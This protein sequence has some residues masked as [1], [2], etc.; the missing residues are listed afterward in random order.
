MTGCD[1]SIYVW[2]T[3]GLCVNYLSLFYPFEVGVFEAGNQS[4]FCSAA[5]LSYQSFLPML[6]K[7][8]T[9]VF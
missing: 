6:T 2:Y 9:L 7:V 1:Q 4:W 8:A 5:M 3:A